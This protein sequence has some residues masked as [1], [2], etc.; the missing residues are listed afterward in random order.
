MDLPFVRR[1]GL[2]QW[3]VLP[4]CRTGDGNAARSDESAQCL[5]AKIHRARATSHLSALPAT[6]IA[7]VMHRRLHINAEYLKR[8][9]KITADAP[10]GLEHADVSSCEHCVIANATH[11]PHKGKKYKPSHVGRLVHGD[12]L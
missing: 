7:D 2:F 8:L 3:A 6:E 4:I 1:E 10:K 12:I 9:P 5:A 11:V